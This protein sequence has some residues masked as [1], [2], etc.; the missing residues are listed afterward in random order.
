[1]GSNEL[2]NS[3]DRWCL[4]IEDKD[5]EEARK[6]EPINNRLI[7]ISEWRKTSKAECTVKFA[8]YPNKF[9]QITY[10]STSSIVIPRVSSERR[11]YIPFGFVDENTIVLDS[12]QAVYVPSAFI[13][14]VITSLMHNLWVKAVAGYLGTSIRYSSVLCYNTF[15]F[16]KILEKQKEEIS[17]LVFNILDEREKHSQKT[18]AQLYDPDKMPEGLKKAHHNLDI[19]I[20]QCYRSKPFE[21]D[22]ERLEYLFKMYEEMTNKE[23]K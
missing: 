7:K 2:I 6:I 17:E 12:A 3:V 19:A 15:P 21:S 5:L 18:L 11:K 9:K 20:E 13:F 22:E 1:M 14:G 10:R 8:E 4:W 23:E 16:P